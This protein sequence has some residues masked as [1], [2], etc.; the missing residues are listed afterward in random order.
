MA[1]RLMVTPEIH[2][3][4]HEGQ[5][6]EIH[7]LLP[8]VKKGDVELNF[9]KTGFCVKGSRSD[10][11]FAACHTLP[12]PVDVSKVTTKYYNVQGLLEI[13]V[14]LLKPIINKR[15]PIR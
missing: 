9:H 3:H 5:R 1:K 12:N 8:R 2:S 7:V 13:T 4:C 6:F 15:I 11:I 10:V 14:P